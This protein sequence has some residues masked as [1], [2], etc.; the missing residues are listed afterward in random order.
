MKRAASILACAATTTLLLGGSGAVPA[1]AADWAPSTFAE[2]ESALATCADGDTVAPT[3]DLTG[4]RLVAACEVTLDLAGHA[5][6]AQGIVIASGTVLTITATGGG[7]LVSSGFGSGAGIQVPTG[8][9]LVIEGGTIVARGDSE[10]DTSDGIAAAGIGGGLLLDGDGILSSGVGD[11]TIDDGTVTAIG[12]DEVTLGGGAAGIGGAW[13]TDVAGGLLTINGGDVEALGGGADPAVPGPPDADGVGIGGTAGFDVVVNGGTVSAT[14]GVASAGIGGRPSQGGADVSITGGVVTAVGGHTAVGAGASGTAFGSLVVGAG[15]VL[16]VPSGPFVISADASIGEPEIVI[17]QGGALLGT[18]ADPTIGAALTGDGEIDNHGVIALDGT[19]IADTLTVTDHDYE[20]GFDPQDGDPVASVRLFAPD[21]ATGYRAIPPPPAGM[22]WTTAA[23]GSGVLFTD[24]TPVTSD[25]TLYAVDE[26]YPELAAAL[27]ECTD[28]STVVVP[29]DLSGPPLVIGCA[30]TLDLAGHTLA[31]DFIDVLGGA[32]LIVDDAVGG[33]R[34]DALHPADPSDAGIHVPPTAALT[35]RAGTITAEGD[36]GAAVGGGTTDSLG[37]AAGTIRIEGGTVN[38]SA[39]NGGAG[40]GGGLGYSGGGGGGDVTITGGEV[41]ARSL[42]GGSG[43]GGGSGYASGGG[44]FPGGPGGSVTVTGGTVDA[45]GVASGIGGGIYNAGGTVV[46]SAGTVT[47]SAAYGS[48]IGGGGSIAGFGS[49]TL[50]GGMLHV[51]T[52]SLLVPD[53]DATAAEITIGSG[54]VLSGS[55]ATPT[56]GANIAGDGQI[57]N[58]GVIAFD[59]ANVGDAITVNDHDY[60]VAFDPQDGGPLASVRLFA[61]DFQ[62]GYRT[63]PAIGAPDAWNTAADG[64]GGWFAAD[65]A[66]TA[67]TTL[68]AVTDATLSL[69]ASSDRVSQGGSL[70]FEVTGLDHEGDPVDTSAVVLSSSVAT[71]VVDGLTVT[72]P[73]ASPH[74]ITATLGDATAAVT[75]EVIPAAAQPASLSSTG[76]DP[77]PALSAA[78]LL[79]FTGAALMLGLMLGRRRRMPRAGR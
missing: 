74:V 48:A 28:G 55:D 2:L 46:V 47:A 32:H 26:T 44:I 31:P 70:S 8:S 12:G 3:G 18:E 5:L 34:L 67:D 77:A 14:G 73:H 6:V 16:R 78:A 72:F 24:T 15:G 52:G 64:T 65:T 57:D 21:F 25:V 50:A 66:V 36:R 13:E 20:V 38:A 33:G 19:L 7:S 29:E 63:I 62:S 37:E 58:H 35:V 49:L 68:Y 71:D 27:A 60:L 51:P 42:F 41:T 54:G 9:G 1:F 4:G 59:G 76:V 79:L 39:T 30:V 11:I 56:V 45:Y 17:E 43:I 23:D 40:I 75:V 61:P 53:S 22:A 10:L 69:V